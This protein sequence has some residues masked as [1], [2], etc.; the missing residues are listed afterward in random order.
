MK[1]VQKK[2]RRKKIVDEKAIPPSQL[3]NVYLNKDPL[4]F[5]RVSTSTGVVDQI[6][7]SNMSR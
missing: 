7:P 3:P 5:K 6:G 2:R 4:G 1:E